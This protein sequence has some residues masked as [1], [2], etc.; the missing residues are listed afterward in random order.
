MGLGLPL[1]LLALLGVGIP[2]WLHRVRRRSL[3]DLPLPTIGL[4]RR[5]VV[6]KRRTLS[7]VDRPLLYTRVALAALAAFA[8]TRPYLS[9][10]ASYA[11]ERPIA[12]AIVL[13]DS[14]SMSRRAAGGGSLFEVALGRA[15]RVLGELAP[16]SE[17]TVVLGGSAP[18]LFSAR[19]S[20]LPALRERLGDVTRAGA[21]GTALGDALALGLRQLS[22]SKLGMREVLVLTD[23]AAHADADTLESDAANVR[24]ECIAARN[25]QPNA[26]IADMRLSQPAEVNGPHTLNVGL[27]AGSQQG[28][29]ELSLAVDG[30]AIGEH[31]VSFNE[32]RANAEIR[33]DSAQ[34]RE[35]R[36]LSARIETPN[37][38]AEDDVRELLLMD[39]A[40]L[41]VLLVDG[42][43][44]P[45][46]L[47]DELRYAAVA[48]S[49]GD[50]ER[51]LPRVTRIDAD[52]LSSADL[53]A[54]HVLVLANVRAPSIE[55][56]E[57]IRLYVK[58]GGG[59]L[60]AAGDQ[61]DAFAYRGSVGD[62]LPAVVRS[63][64][65][66]SPPL[67]IQKV[68]STESILLPEGG[69][70]LETGGT[71]K[72]LLLEPPNQGA[73]TLLQFADGGALL[74]AGPHGQGRVALWTT[75]LDDDWTDLPLT[76][77]FLPL[78]TGLVRGL[79]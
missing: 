66:A 32:G 23:C 79:A 69:R 53:D 26:Y 71:T 70:G 10:L 29:L 9:R 17:A 2:L 42:D 4:L 35:A 15:E 50:G 61:V 40:E 19:T 43:P 55:V 22:A 20:E 65:P 11:T 28:E 68:A 27:V 62:L 6:Q 41:S 67:A 8:L 44:A 36:T 47:D 60:I 57:R 1:A 76:P 74:V 13:D 52:G 73:T 33:I 78:L 25:A 58:R 51:T 18:R 7:F 46:Q 24:V 45:N 49:V 31:T 54:Y 38:V 21:R 12:L 59:L 39:R 14:M 16:E 56:A 75:T 5:A 64:A 30:K 3:R 48:L 72:R 77:G 63:S 34:L 37:A